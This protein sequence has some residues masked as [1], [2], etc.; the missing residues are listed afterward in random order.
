MPIKIQ[1]KVPKLKRCPI[2][3]S[4]AEI[5]ENILY[6]TTAYRVQCK[7]CALNTRHYSADIRTPDE[8]MELAATIWNERRLRPWPTRK[9]KNV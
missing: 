6:Y 9:T 7:S 1:I 4:K 2:C 8:A 5:R 3:K